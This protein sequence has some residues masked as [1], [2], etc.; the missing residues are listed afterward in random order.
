MVGYALI[1]NNNLESIFESALKIRIPSYTIN[2]Y[3]YHW[4][5]MYITDDTT[6][7]IPNLP[8]AD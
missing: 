6:H 3:V 1:V 8:K 7:P 2:K 5:N 4:K